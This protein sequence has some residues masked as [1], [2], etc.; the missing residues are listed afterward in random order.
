L[1]VVP[2]ISANDHGLLPWR[3]SNFGNVRRLGGVTYFKM[4]RGRAE[5]WQQVYM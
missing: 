4:P 5:P 2:C 3:T 1:I